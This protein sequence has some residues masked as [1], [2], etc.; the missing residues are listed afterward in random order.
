MSN[1]SMCCDDAMSYRNRMRPYLTAYLKIG[2]DS[3]DSHE[4]EGAH[5]LGLGQK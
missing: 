3:P 4:C 1:A 5:W 2:F